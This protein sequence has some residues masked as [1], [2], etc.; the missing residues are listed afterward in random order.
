[1][2]MEQRTWDSGNG[3]VDM[4]QCYME[5]GTRDGQKGTVNMGQ[6]TWDSG[7]GTV[8]MGQWTWESGHGAGDMGWWRREGGHGTVNMEQ[9][10]GD[11]GYGTVDM[12]QW[13]WNKGH[14]TVDISEWKTE[15]GKKQ[16]EFTAADNIGIGKELFRKDGRS[17]ETHKKINKLQKIRNGNRVEQLKII[18][19]NLGSKLWCNK[20]EDIELLLSEFKPDLCY[21]SEANLWNGLDH[22]EREILG[23]EII[24][25]NTMERL[26]HA[27]IILLVREGISVVKLNQYMESDTATIWVRV[28]SSRKKSIIVGGIYRQHRVLGVTDKEASRLDL[29]LEQEERW[30]RVVKH[31][32]AASN[33]ANCITM[34]DINLDYK[35]WQEPEFLQENMI[36]MV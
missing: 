6:G 1:M 35:R 8:E 20:L 28:G 22:H 18:H 4:E 36:E 29:K 26:G 15:N 12:E 17:E 25:P 16:L 14:G 2:N 23:H 27:R 5:Q 13:T 34:G 24:Y 21:I 19:W 7:N 11:S 33:N 10:T 31:W 9:W 30:K 32:K 3:T